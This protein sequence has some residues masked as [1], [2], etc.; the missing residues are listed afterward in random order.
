MRTHLIGRTVT[1]LFAGLILLLP[2][3]TPSAQ[4]RGK[5]AASGCNTPPPSPTSFVPVPGHPF[6]VV[7]TRDGCY[8]FVSVVSDARTANG[9]AVLGRSAGRLTLKHLYELGVTPLGMVL[10][11]DGK[12]LVVAA[13]K[14]VVFM[15]V[16]RMLGNGQRNPILGSISDGDSAG[17]VYVNVTSDDGFLFVSDE[18]AASITVIDLKKARASGFSASAIVGKIPVGRAPIALTFSPDGRWLYTTSQIA[19]EKLGWPI[20]CKPEGAAPETAAAKNPKGAII[21]V[22]VERAK[23]DPAG[24]IVSYVPAGCSPVRLAITPSGDRA[25]VTARNSNALL[26]F[27]SEKLRKDP[28]NALIGTVPVGPAPVGVAVVNKGRQVF[29]TNSNRFSGNPDSRQ[30]LTVIDTA[31]VAQG[32]RAISGTIQAGGFPREFALSPDGRTLFVSNFNS[33]E[34]QIIDL[35]HMPI[36]V[37]NSTAATENH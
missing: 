1:V 17:S 10:T 11:H 29:V 35:Q 21:V 28:A 3:G 37:A 2:S 13:S 30:T 5:P 33:N 18:A 34:I 16:G 14:N 20:D 8:L 26:A 32:S 23:T 31:H 27:D 25:F 15:D 9:I 22:D 12:V 24:S 7:P 19:P 4:Q 36:A 6:G